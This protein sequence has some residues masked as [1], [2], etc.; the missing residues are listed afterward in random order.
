VWLARYGDEGSSFVSYQLRRYRASLPVNHF[1]L[2]SLLI[3][4]TLSI[5]CE[6][7][8]YSQPRQLYDIYE[9]ETLIHHGY[10]ISVLRKRINYES[11]PV[12][13]AYAVIK[14][15]EKI[16]AEFA[17]GP[18]HPVGN[19]ADFGRFDLLG[20]GTQPVIIS[21]TVP[22]GGRHWVV[23]LYPE[24]RVLFDSGDYGVGREEFYV[25]DIDRDGIYEISL[26]VTAFYQMQ[27]KMYIGEIPLPEIVFKYD[28]T[29]KKYMPANHLH[30]DYT[31][32]RLDGEIQALND[33]DNYLSKRLH[34]LLRYIYA[35]REQ[36]GWAFFE[37]AYR[38]PDKKE[39]CA[40]IKD[41]L[42]NSPLYKY[43]YREQ[44]LPNNLQKIDFK[45]YSYG[46]Y[47][48][49]HG[50]RINLKLSDGEY[51][52]NFDE[53]RG[54][55]RLEDVYY[56]DLTGDGDP[57]AI[58]ILSIVQ[59]G[60]SCDGGANLFRIYAPQKKSLQTIWRYETGAT[61]YGCGLKS[62]TA[63]PK[64][65]VMEL[66]GRCPKQGQESSGPGKFLIDDMTRL[67][68][69]FNG[70]HFVRQKIEFLTTATNDTKNY[71]PQIVIKTVPPR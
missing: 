34:I 71:K 58:V 31:L 65:I 66:F 5:A 52:Y 56:A 50:R 25:I 45:N 64:E 10:E 63:K 22:R 53:V 57:E 70:R 20:D 37:K 12:E 46:Q 40:R 44:N 38:R 6:R 59:C 29:Q 36:E 48:F 24:F 41:V 13:V 43:L 8:T 27:D 3:F 47:R 2:S 16:V 15:D 28:S 9:G 60:I 21:T 18:V 67:T 4:A 26:E 30:A 7:R 23:S 39:I 19:S 62:F 55:F 61:A 11:I 68:F 69:K 42:T 54:W 35:G 32:R 51:K 14:R 49:P 17:G 1:F 33:T